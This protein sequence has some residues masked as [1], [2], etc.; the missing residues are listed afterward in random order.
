MKVTLEKNY[1]DI[2]TI[3]DL[4]AAKMVITYEKD[5]EDT[6]KGWAEYAVREALK[7]RNDA[8]DH[9]IEADART[10]KN[11]RAWELYGEGTRNFDVWITATAETS[12]G[13]VKIGACLSDIW[14]TGATTYKNHMFIQYFTEA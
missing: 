13:F 10:T 3:T 2:Y 4:E 6:A 1:K 5:D 8:L 14:Q 12:R 7:G 11:S 9:V